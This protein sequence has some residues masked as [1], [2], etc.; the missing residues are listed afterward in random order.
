VQRG[1]DLLSERERDESKNESENASDSAA[2]QRESSEGRAELERV[3]LRFSCQPDLALVGLVQTYVVSRRLYACGGGGR[4][5]RLAGWGPSHPFLLMRPLSIRLR[6][7]VAR[8]ELR[9]AAASSAS[10]ESL[11]ELGCWLYA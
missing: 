7:R 11:P 3:L 1:P 10:T 9:L 5:E 2:T 6:L 8:C 4:G